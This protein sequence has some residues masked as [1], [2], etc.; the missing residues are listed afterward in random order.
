MKEKLINLKN[1]A[2]YL[3]VAI[4]LV[5]CV[6]SL[7]ACGE[8][9]AKKSV[10]YNTKDMTDEQITKYFS[11]KVLQDV[12]NDARNRSIIIYEL[13]EKEQELTMKWALINEAGKT[14]IDSDAETGIYVDSNAPETEIPIVKIMIGWDESDLNQEWTVEIY[15][16]TTNG[17]ETVKNVVDKVVINVSSE[18]FVK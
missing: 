4:M 2:R 10:V 5:V 14:I 15:Y 17:S 8:A 1:I 18:N 16:E 13:D 11:E 9:S 7:T 12:K 6:L 3:L